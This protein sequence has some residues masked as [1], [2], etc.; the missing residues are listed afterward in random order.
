M[1]ASPA[2]V[3]TVVATW[4]DELA[5]IDYTLV[6]IADGPSR[7]FLGMNGQGHVPIRPV[8]AARMIADHPAAPQ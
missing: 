1:S 7:F 3:P 8:D 4:W 5:Q 2:G 6:E